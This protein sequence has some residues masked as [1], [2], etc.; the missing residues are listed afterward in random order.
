MTLSE[1]EA[2]AMKKIRAACPESMMELESFVTDREAG[3]VFI[4]LKCK[5]IQDV[6]DRAG[7]GY[8]GTTE[9]GLEQ[10]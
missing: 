3:R 1:V 7:S 8:S 5:G 2:A 10:E 9:G 4:V 6:A